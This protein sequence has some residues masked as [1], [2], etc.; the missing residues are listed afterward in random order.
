MRHIG[1]AAL[2]ATIMSAGAI[3]NATAQDI[4][5][6]RQVAYWNWTGFYVGANVGYGWAR[7]SLTATSGAATATSSENLN[8]ILGGG[9]IGAN[10]QMGNMVFGVETD[11]QASGQSKSSSFSG[12]GLTVVESDKI[13]WFG[14]TRARFGFA[15]DRFLGYVTG[16]IGYGEFRSDLT[17]SGTTTGTLSYST[18]RTAWVVGGGVE[19]LMSNNLTWR[20]EYLHLDT[21]SFSVLSAGGVN[22]SARLTDEIVRLGL[23]YRFR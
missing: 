14:T 2:A 21:G 4:L 3:E 18:T 12:G 5:S 19:G 11:F 10:Y 1:F 8:G 15:A 22:V 9:Q 17:F 7:G 20:V 23:N 16:G 6:P 13:P